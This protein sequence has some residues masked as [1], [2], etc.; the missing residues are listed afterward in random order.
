MIQ[1]IIKILVSAIAISIAAFFSPMQVTNYSAAIMASIV[2]GVLD[3]AINKFLGI[4]ASPAG[5]GTVG[6]ITAA[7][8][9]YLTGRIVDGFSASIIGSLIGAFV[10]GIVDALIP[11]NKNVFKK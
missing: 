3:W 5:R 9:I 2:I 6:F 1:L 7:I 8:I 4:K 11:G 10:I